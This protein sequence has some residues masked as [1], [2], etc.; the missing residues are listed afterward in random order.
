M[1]LFFIYFECLWVR[2]FLLAADY[3][4]KNN[5]YSSNKFSRAKRFNN[6]IITANFK[7]N[8]TVYFFPSGSKK[9]NRNIRVLSYYF[10]Y[11]KPFISGKPTSR[12]TRSIF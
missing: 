6:I 11:S 4:L 7:T 1:P 9:N 10:T 12:I 5:F 3:P 8:N 2:I